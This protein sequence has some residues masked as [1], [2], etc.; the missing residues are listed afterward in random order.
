[1]CSI[2]DHHWAVIVSCFSRY[3][4]F[5]I[6]SVYEEVTNSNWNEIQYFQKKKTS[7]FY[8][9]EQYQRKDSE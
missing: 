6:P 3:T 5:K 4:C 2:I 9:S 7:H 1:M 8:D